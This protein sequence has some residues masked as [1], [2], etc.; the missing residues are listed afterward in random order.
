MT[1]IVNIRGNATFV[2]VTDDI[3]WQPEETSELALAIARMERELPGWWW[4]VG[5]CHVSSDA[6]CGPD[7]HGPDAQLLESSEFSDL[8]D[9]GIFDADIPQP[10]TCA[11]ALNHVIDKAIAW[12]G[13]SSSTVEPG[14]KAGQVEHQKKGLQRQ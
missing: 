12:R 2:T 13:T 6:S 5:A 11:Q 10:S 9:T 7:S 1:E 8:L 4:S 14:T 3:S